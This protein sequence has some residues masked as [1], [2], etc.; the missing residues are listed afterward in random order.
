MKYIKSLMSLLIVFISVMFINVKAT[1]NEPFV[2]TTKA[3]PND[4]MESFR[5]ATPT[6]ATPIYK[7]GLATIYIEPLV[8]RDSNKNYY[9]YDIEQTE[10]ELTF[11]EPPLYTG[12][13]Y[14]HFF[15]LL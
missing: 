15:H 3:R 8:K 9:L 7:N 4:I 12:H 1:A 11:I 5:T 6:V 13:H 14:K 10:S 2:D